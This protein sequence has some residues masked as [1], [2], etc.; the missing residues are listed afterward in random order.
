[1]AAGSV[2]FNGDRCAQPVAVVLG[3]SERP[4]IDSTQGTHRA[5]A[6]H[7]HQS[8]QVEGLPTGLVWRGEQARKKRQVGL[9]NVTT[10]PPPPAAGSL[11]TS[12]DGE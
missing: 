12:L 10:P 4:L 11:L 6:G 5:S 7:K 1:M 2:P 3:V 9:W 8:E